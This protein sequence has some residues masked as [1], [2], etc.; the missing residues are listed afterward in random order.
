MYQCFHCGAYS[1]IW[2]SDFSFEDFCMD[3]EGIVHICYCTNCG[4]TIEYYVPI[5]VEEEVENEST[6]KEW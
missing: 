6:E 1:V 4:A 5:D 3:G 2:Q